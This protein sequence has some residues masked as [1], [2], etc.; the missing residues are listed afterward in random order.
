L[1]K[2]LVNKTTTRAFMIL[3]SIYSIWLAATFF[4]FTV[5]C[6]EPEM[7]EA[8]SPVIPDKEL[9]VSSEKLTT[10][11]AQGLKQIALSNGQVELAALV[12]YDVDVYRLTY[13][14]TYKGKEV[15][16][17]GLVTVPLK[18]T[19]A[20]PILSAHHGT[21]FDQQY[22]PSNF[23]LNSLTGFEVFGAVGYLT[24]VPDYLGYMVSK[25]IFHPYYDAK[26]SGLAVVD[27][28]KAGKSFFK[29]NNIQASEDLF[30][31]GY[32]EGG[33]VT[34]AAQKEIEENPAHGL[35][36]TASGAGA[37]G[38]DLEGMLARVVS[39]EAYQYPANLAFILHA[40]NVTYDWNRPMT[41]FF[42]EPYASR[43]QELLNGTRSSSSI[44]PALATDPAKLFN[45]AFLA[46][47]KGEG[48]QALK[49]ALKRNSLKH[50]VPKSPTRLYHGTADNM[51][52]YVNST[53]TFEAM[54]AAGATQVKFVPIKEGT[55]FSSLE[56]M[57]RD[58]IPWIEGFRTQQ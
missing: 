20:A 49:T 22:A 23:S 10:V 8:P 3:K 28:I 50:F 16:V 26:H 6:K 14:T 47:L 45:P 55:H 5:S 4:G 56:P 43:L 34:L 18:I 30:L 52:P 2:N 27:M 7:P 37:G 51:V 57:I 40:Y 44:N 15:K 42:Q 39:G 58:L 9:L 53:V 21:T 17:S 24:V 29:K 36:V 31:A 1:G 54:K 41:D 35:T 12:K 38:Y 19:S 33:Y 46:A 32:S 48:E 25:Q 11:T 13:L